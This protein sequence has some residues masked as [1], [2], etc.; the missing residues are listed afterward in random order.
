[1]P[2]KP[3]N[4]DEYTQYES[5]GI[6]VYVR[7]DVETKNGELTLTVMKFLFKESLVVEGIAY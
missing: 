1:M 5:N 2:G 7:N 4:A 6:N 3:V